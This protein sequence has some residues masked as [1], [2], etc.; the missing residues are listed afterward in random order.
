MQEKKKQKKKKREEKRR[1]VKVKGGEEG[2]RVRGRQ[3]SSKGEGMGGE[4][5]GAEKKITGTS[6]QSHAACASDIS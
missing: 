5:A 2:K 1:K 6:E 3:K 4:D